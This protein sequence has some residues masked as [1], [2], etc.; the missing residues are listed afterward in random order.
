MLFVENILFIFYKLWK[1]KFKKILKYL[2]L[3]A[4]KLKIEKMSAN[5]SLLLLLILWYYLVF[6]SF[7]IEIIY[8]VSKSPK[9]VWENE[10]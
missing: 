3:K 9:I 2:I 8:S 4:K 1:T 5:S 7:Y 6:H 10:N